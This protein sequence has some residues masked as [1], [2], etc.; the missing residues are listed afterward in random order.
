MGWSGLTRARYPDPAHTE[1]AF[2]PIGEVHARL[3]SDRP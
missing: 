3:V 1:R 2:N